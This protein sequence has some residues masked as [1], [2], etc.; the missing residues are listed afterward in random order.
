MLMFRISLMSLSPRISS[1]L[2]L[3]FLDPNGVKV[4]KEVES[5]G[6]HWS[7]HTRLQPLR[8][9]YLLSYPSNTFFVSHI[10]PIHISSSLHESDRNCG[11]MSSDAWRGQKALEEKR[12][13]EA[14]EHLTKALKESQ[15]P[16]WLLDRSTAYQRNGQH[17]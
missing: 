1:S 4:N 16:V 14:I 13:P 12:Y 17:E 6:R 11:K 10:S 5:N 7:V 8:I 9:I 15:S 2:K 3:F